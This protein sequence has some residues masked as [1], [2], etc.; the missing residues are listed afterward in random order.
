MPEPVA[1]QESDL[2]DLLDKELKALPDK[3]RAP[4]ILCGLEG[5][6]EKEAAG[7]LGLAQGTLSSRLSRARAMLAKRLARHGVA[8][9][10]PTASAHVPTALLDS[11]IKAA[12]QFAAGQAATTGLISAEV[13]A[14]TKGV[15][16]A[17]FLS[18]IKVAIAVLLV[19]VTIIS[20]AGVLVSQASGPANQEKRSEASSPDAQQSEV[21]SPK[22]LPPDTMTYAPDEIAI[23]YQTN[24][25][26]A[27]EKFTGKRV[28]VKGK[29]L[30]IIGARLPPQVYASPG[31]Q[32]AIRGERIYYLEMTGVE[33]PRPTG[34][35]VAGAVVA[36]A[37][38]AGAAPLLRFQFTQDDRDQLAKLKVGQEVTVE[39]QLLEP[40]ENRDGAV[41][42]IGIGVHKCRII[43]Q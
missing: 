8:L 32:Q 5:R 27:D 29:I 26:L 33:K 12:S 30:R 4:L 9:S 20:G 41:T 7:Q 2:Q 39:G 36:G 24:A 38:V 6:T 22:V 34:A 17:M 18:Q 13:A 3:Y 43:N 23:A 16:T 10:L 37:V 1:P 15:L 28:A 14:L 11:T 42:R 35:V 40:S 25:A 19:A 31:N 21:A